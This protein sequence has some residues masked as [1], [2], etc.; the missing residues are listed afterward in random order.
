M[1]IETINKLKSEVKAELVQNILPFWSKSMIDNVNGGFYGR[2]DGDGKVYPEDDK[3]CILNARILWSFSSVCRVLETK[4]YLQYAQR[5]KDYLLK[6]FIDREFGGVYWLIDCKGK[7]I[8][9]KK[10]I[11]AQAFAIYALTEYYRVTWDEACLAQAI[12]L[13]RLIEKYSYDATEEGYFEAFGRDWKD[14]GDLRLSEK[15]AN[16]KKTMNTHLHVLEAYTNLYRVW[17]DAGL[18]LQLE[19]LI[20]IFIA[21]IVHPETCNL[22]MFMDENWNDKT[23]LVSYGHNIEASWLLYEAAHVLG[24]ESITQ[25]VKK[26]SIN[27]ADVT[28]EGLRPD[29]SIVYERFFSN[30]HIDTDRHWW[31]QAEA[32]V[33]YMNAYELTGDREYLNKGLAAWKFISEHIIDRKGGEWYWSVNDKMEPNLKN[34]KAGFWK[35]PYHNSRM[36]LEVIE[37]KIV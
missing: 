33:G 1:V 14:I 24:N 10:Q 22:K 3:G 18:R 6:Y 25:R 13:Y 5:A 16:E 15:D 27:I 9:G 4:E 31:P 2:I 23:D 21:K 29:G 28:F 37:R 34:D 7:V 8:D 17:K 32:V 26:I 19:K 35:C 36:C 11:Y 30:N 12:D 20:D